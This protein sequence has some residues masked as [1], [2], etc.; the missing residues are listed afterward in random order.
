MTTLD[1]FKAVSCSYKVYRT[2]DISVGK[3]QGSDSRGKCQWL[4]Y[5]NWVPNSALHWTAISLRSFA[6]SELGTLRRPM[7]LE[8]QCLSIMVLGCW[9]Q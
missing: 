6:A 7:H 1:F 2:H 8:M 3:K 9:F 4:S 5:M